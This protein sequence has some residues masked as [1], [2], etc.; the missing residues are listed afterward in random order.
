MYIVAFCK[1]LAYCSGDEK[2][3]DHRGRNPK[4]TVEIW[5]AIK[6]VEKGSSRIQRGY[7]ATKDLGSVNIKELGVE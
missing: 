5:I 1:V 4:R 7:T 6:D 3:K 2:N